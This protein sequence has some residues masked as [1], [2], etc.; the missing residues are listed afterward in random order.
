MP[1][2]G[3]VLIEAKKN[4]IHLTATDLEVGVRGQVEGEVTKEGTV[5]VNAKKLYDERIS[6]SVVYY[7]NLAGSGF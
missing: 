2:L 3:N 7:R 5:T 1:I 6:P 4:A